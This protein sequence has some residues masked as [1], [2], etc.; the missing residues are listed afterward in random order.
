MMHFRMKLETI[1]AFLPVGH[2]RHRA[3]CGRADYLKTC[4]QFG[5]AIA[6]RHPDDEIIMKIIE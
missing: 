5:D 4:R 1:K 6:M 3:V 2:G